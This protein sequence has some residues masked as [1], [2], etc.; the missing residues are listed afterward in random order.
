LPIDLKELFEEREGARSFRVRNAAYKLFETAY[1]SDTGDSSDGRPNL[2]LTYRPNNIDNVSMGADNDLKKIAVNQ[3]RRV[4]AHFGSM[5]SRRPRVFVWPLSEQ[6]SERVE[7]E[8]DY[9][10]YVFKT[11]NLDVLHTRQSHYL[12]LRGDAVFG[13]DWNPMEQTRPQV[14]VKVYDPQHCY[15]LFSPHDLG[16]VEDMLVAM[17]VHPSWARITFDLP[18]G[19]VE[20][21]KMASLFYY[22]TA[23]EC[24]VQVEDYPVRREYRKHELG[25]CPFRWVFGDPS[26]LMAQADCREVPK[27]QEVFNEALLLTLDAVRKQVDPA[28]WVTGIPKDVTPEPGVANA[29]PENS[30]VGRWEIGADPQIIMSVMSSLEDAIYTTTGVSP[31]S[32]R[33]QARGSIVS[34]SAVRHQVEASDARSDTRKTL[35]E[36]TYARL[37]EMVLRTTNQLYPQELISFL[38]QKGM[39]RVQG[40]EFSHQP[41]CGATYGDF[42]S[43]SMETRFQ[44][45]MQGLG[46]LWDDKYAIGQVLDLPGTRPG[47]MVHRLKAYQIQQA[48]ITA[49]AQAAAQHVAQEAQGGQDGQQAPGGAPGQAQPQSP[50]PQ[51]PQRPQ[52]PTG[53][54]LR[55]ALGAYTGASNGT[56]GGT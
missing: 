54:S 21:D 32:M 22:W 25:F 56:G 34:G 53:Q 30:Q 50:S 39:E 51:R 20:P 45:A 13:V 47:E 9:I 40:K 35:L 48:M 31:I 10:E 36:G 55:R 11:S 3:V 19:V 28:W 14:M 37:G 49:E 12:S 18:R 46:R 42:I 33:G 15:P 8:A 16:G 26:G 5:F 27:I 23:D 4:V 6:D 44:I 17:R 52:P 1:N 7:R 24:Y 2:D 38:G 41:V 29:L 43:Q